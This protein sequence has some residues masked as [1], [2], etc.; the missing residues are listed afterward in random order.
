M[1]SL[2]RDAGKPR[3]MRLAALAVAIALA[4]LAQVLAGMAR[5]QERIVGGA[6][7]APDSL[8]FMAAIWHAGKPK[9]PACDGTLIAPR[10]V[11]TAASC[12]HAFSPFQP[13]AAATYR[14]LP[15]G[16]LSVSFAGPGGG[17]KDSPRMSVESVAVHPGYDIDRC[18]VPDFWLLVS[19][20]DDVAILRLASAPA[21]AAPVGLPRS[22][23]NALTQAGAEVTVAGWSAAR[24]LSP[25]VGAL[26]RAALTVSQPGLCE[27][28]YE[29][30]GERYGMTPRVRYDRAAAFCAYEASAGPCYGEMGGPALARA[31]GEW[32]QVGV[33]GPVAFCAEAKWPSI[34]TRVSEPTVNRWIRQAAG[35]EAGRAG[36]G[37]KE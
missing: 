36:K 30:L 32:V 22:G 5:G 34:F 20:R 14:K 35:L 25:G 3:R 19:C 1:S 4:V 7:A 21:G 23:Q 8:P 18:L 9:D 2:T 10:M 24:A 33:L 26:T 13:D 6:P 11:L 27:R 15:A 31:G 17:V 37:A 12:V 16:E 29:G 28:R